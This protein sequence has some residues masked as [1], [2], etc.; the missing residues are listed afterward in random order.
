MVAT[1]WSCTMLENAELCGSN[2]QKRG[3]VD[4]KEEEEK[5]RNRCFAIFVLCIPDCSS[6]CEVVEEVDGEGEA[7]GLRVEHG[8]LRVT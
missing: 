1:P 5:L 3:E 8:K 6:T 4:T 2:S 7:G